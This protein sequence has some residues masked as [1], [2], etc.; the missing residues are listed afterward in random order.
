MFIIARVFRCYITVHMFCKI[1]KKYSQLERTLNMIGQCT[2]W[3]SVWY[4]NLIDFED[5][6]DICLGNHRVKILACSM[7]HAV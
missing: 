2:C 1:F 3:L 4:E 7:N 6:I 5:P